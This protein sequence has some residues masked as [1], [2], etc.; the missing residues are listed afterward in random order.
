MA[1]QSDLEAY[2]RWLAERREDTDY[3][4]E[5][6]DLDLDGPGDEDEDEDDFDDLDEE[7]V[8]EEG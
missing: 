5:D 4:F 2:A 1:T 8:D 6:A 7:V 3:G